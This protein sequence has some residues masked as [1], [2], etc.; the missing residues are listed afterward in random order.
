MPLKPPVFRPTHLGPKHERQQQLRRLDQRRGS[1][2]SRGYDADWRRLRLI[3]LEEEPLCRFHAERGQTVPGE[4][5]DHI[6]PVDLR[7][8]LRLVRSNLRV[9]CKACHS[10]L[11]ASGVQRR[12]AKAPYE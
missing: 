4:E 11:T 12:R 5:V 8:D 7:P 2:A 10:R 9:L 1:S 3:V 6:E